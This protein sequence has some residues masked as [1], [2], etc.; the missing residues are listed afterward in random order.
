VLVRNKFINGKYQK[1]GQKRNNNEGHP[2]GKGT[3]GK[4]KETED[5]SQSKID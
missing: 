1:T 5:F 4:E 3:E 2:G